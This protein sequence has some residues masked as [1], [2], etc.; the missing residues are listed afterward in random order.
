M[1]RGR[2]NSGTRSSMGS[3]SCSAPPVATCAAQGTGVSARAMS[4]PAAHATCIIGQGSAG[5]CEDTTHIC[6]STHMNIG[7]LHG[8]GPGTCRHAWWVNNALWF[9]TRMP[10]PTHMSC[11]C[12]KRSSSARGLS[13]RAWFE[14]LCMIFAS[15]PCMD[16][17][18]RMLVARAARA[19]QEETFSQ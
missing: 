16:A 7:F 13:L 12:F 17:G 18:M 15:E 14:P 1:S 5:D 6:L 11:P 8:L 4:A 10:Y 2:P 19:C 9:G 3:A